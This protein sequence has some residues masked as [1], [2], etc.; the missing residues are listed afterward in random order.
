MEKSEITVPDMP[1]MRE[2]FKILR[3][4]AFISEDCLSDSNRRFYRVIDD[5]F[6]A[7]F[8][9]FLQLG[10]YLEK[11]YG[12]VHLCEARP[13]G[14]IQSKLRTDVGKYI[15][16]IAVLMKFRPELAP[17]SQFKSYE[18]QMFCDQDDEMRSVLPESDNGQ[19]SSRITRFLENVA[20]EGVHRPVRRR[21]DLLCHV[22]FPLPEGIRPAHTP[23][24]RA[25]QVQP[26][27]GDGAGGGNTSGGSINRNGGIDHGI[28]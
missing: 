6:E 9:Y 24:R 20:K 21:D 11:G 5:H 18:L 8:K 26:G 23:V 7:Y 16:M 4:G 2:I 19:L 17:G 28:P 3:T 25:R 27:E 14:N 1:Y 12:Y 22:S 15:E 13:A 10:F